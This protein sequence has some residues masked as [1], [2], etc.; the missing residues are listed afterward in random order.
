M[1]SHTN[2]VTES[3]P[4]SLAPPPMAH[5]SSGQRESDATVAGD[6]GS[7]TSTIVDDDLALAR[8]E[9]VEEE[10]E[11]EALGPKPGEKGWDKY[12]VTIGPDDPEHPQNW[13]RA[14][15]WYLTML[16]GLLVLNA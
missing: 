15:R 14:Y 13:S 9:T 5:L 16:G 6:T 1:A 8:Q 3:S 4:S 11:R 7:H 12:E 2:P 10:F